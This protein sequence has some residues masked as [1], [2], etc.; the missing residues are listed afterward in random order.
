MNRHT[1]TAIV[2]LAVFAAMVLIVM[3][4]PVGF[5]AWSPGQTV[6]LLGE[7]DSGPVVEVDGAQTYPA[8]GAILLTTVSQTRA[9]ASLRFPQAIM[10]YLSAAHDVFLRSD[11]YPTGVDAT[12][13]TASD[14][15]LM[16]EAKTQAAVAALREAGLTVREAPRVTRVRVSGPSNGILQPGD[17]ILA[18]DNVPVASVDDAI[19]RVRQ[20]S[21]GDVVVVSFERDGRIESPVTIQTVPS[22]ND[23][24]VA[25]IGVTLAS[26]F[27][28]SPQVTYRI[29]PA[30]GGNS[31]GLALALAIYDRLTEPD[32]TGGLQVAATGAID[33]RG[34]VA[35]I[36]GVNEKVAAALAQGAE[37]FLLPA[38]NCADLTAPPDGIRLVPVTSLSTAITVMEILTRPGSGTPLP[39][40]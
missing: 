25:T 1:K 10:A 19:D 24:R 8:S 20:K 21:V 14:L 5:V 4:A 2:A 17:I 39:S 36:G 31:A 3:L 15:A 34:R 16:D 18:V 9:D 40:C 30:I 7:S 26:E 35:A 38:T 6:D 29:D 12:Q 23:G 22:S 33:A 28:F 37:V 11:V 13:A 32:L 27:F